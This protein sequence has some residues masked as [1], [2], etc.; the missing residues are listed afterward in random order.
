MKPPPS[1]T[2]VRLVDQAPRPDCV[3]VPGEMPKLEPRAMPRLA[4]PSGA[5]C[6]RM[7][8]WRVYQKLGG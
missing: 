3:A 7:P 2:V 5:Q 6:D 8:L 4:T 1:L